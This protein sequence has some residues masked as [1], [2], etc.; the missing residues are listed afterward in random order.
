MLRATTAIAL[1]LLLAGAGCSVRPKA[2][3]SQTGAEVKEMEDVVG[4]VDAE[5]FG[6]AQLDDVEEGEQGDAMKDDD[7]AV[8]IDADVKTFDASLSGVNAEDFGATALSD[9]QVGL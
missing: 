3:E 7:A 8:A 5:D 1:S 9:T 2:P 4:S 6:N